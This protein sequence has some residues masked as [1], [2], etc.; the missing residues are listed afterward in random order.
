MAGTIHALLLLLIVAGSA[1]LLIRFGKRPPSLWRIGLAVGIGCV[2]GFFLG[3]MFVHACGAGQPFTQWLIPSLC[4]VLVWIF[5]GT[6]RI[7]RWVLT[8]V[9]VVAT[10]GLSQHYNGLVHG[11]QYT[12]NP[13]WAMRVGLETTGPVEVSTLWHTFFTGLYGKEIKSNTPATGPEK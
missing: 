4:L 10:F 12:G 5:L 6:R 11:N 3:A 8:F 9:F 2:N 7:L 13:E 1:F